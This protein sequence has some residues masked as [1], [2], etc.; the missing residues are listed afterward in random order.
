MNVTTVR[1]LLLEGS[2]P[3]PGVRVD[4]LMSDQP[5]G[6]PL[7]SERTDS[8]GEV[9]FHHG[10][11]PLA[12]LARIELRAVARSEGGAEV[13][14]SRIRMSP[15]R[16][17]RRITVPVALDTARAE[18]LVGTKQ[19]PDVAR[20]QADWLVHWRGRLA[21]PGP[22]P[23]FEL[24]L[25]RMALEGVAG[26]AAPTTNRQERLAE[27]ARDRLGLTAGAVKKVAG[28]ARLGLDLIDGSSLG[29]DR[30]TEQD[31]AG[32]L[33]EQQMQPGGAGDTLVRAMSSGAPDPRAGLGSPRAGTPFTTDPDFVKA[34]RA[35]FDDGTLADPGRTEMAALIDAGARQLVAPSVNLVEVW[36]PVLRNNLRIGSV[37]DKRLTVQEL[38]AHGDGWA[39]AVVELDVPLD[40]N[41]CLAAV[42]D[43][44]GDQAFIIDAR[45]GQTLR[46][47]GSGFV[48]EQATVR[49]GFR[50]WTGESDGRL[51]FA[52]A[53]QPIPGLDG[54]ALDV[55]GSGTEAPPG[56]TAEAFLGDTMVLTWPEAA[57]REGLYT[58][59]FEFENTTEHLSGV[60]QTDAPGC[61]V[62][63]DRGPVTSA[64]LHVVVL[65]RLEPRRA[66]ATLTR[67]RCEDETDHEDLLVP[68][69]DDVALSTEAM[70]VRFAVDT[71]GELTQEDTTQ[72]LATADTRIW[73]DPQTWEP[74]L[75]AWPDNA[76]DAQ[77]LELAEVLHVGFTAHEVEGDTDRALIR[78]LLVA[79]LILITI[80]VLL[81]LATA[82]ILLIALLVAAGAIPVAL[83][84]AA[85]APILQPLLGFLVG[86]AFTA[87]LSAVEAMVASVRGE[88]LIGNASLTFTGR[89]LASRLS[90]YRYHRVLYLDERPASDPTQS[91]S[92]TTRTSS[93]VTDA[94][95]EEVF[96]SRALGGD[97]RF[98]VIC[99][100]S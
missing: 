42:S 100:A 15:A 28:L 33:A 78:G 45:P 97:Y 17:V 4:L 91:V 72:V 7:G 46:L 34:C 59:A 38:V 86:A 87:A 63:V 93:R 12:G 27:H 14:T 64:I 55:F 62:S 6:T 53:A 58:L 32:H 57:V 22:Q 9:R 40:D 44:T 82:V 8:R 29:T 3:L 79:A 90:P 47:L 26:I 20:K 96:R 35:A 70:T 11:A 75:Q 88:A 99:A 85:A 69:A 98:T 36:D 30:C 76:V 49:A 56:A 24:C 19:T 81:Y 67:V 95:I 48:A 84:T 65:P 1:V 52:T 94:G 39:S 5:A 31:G 43:G 16:P 68:L 66:H 50:A 25:A 80:A 54:T 51:T 21:K 13:G 37:P 71:A 10:P 18:G 61:R 83:G 92:N 89:E 2:V 60:T 74:L 23:A 41:S 73:S 77:L